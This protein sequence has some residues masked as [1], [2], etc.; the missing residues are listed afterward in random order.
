MSARHTHNEMKIV[1]E[2]TRRGK[3]R[4]KEKK[5][6]ETIACVCVYVKERDRERQHEIDSIHKR[7]VVT[8]ET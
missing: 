1:R 5:R 7:E 4:V 2:K 8:S 3:R 6:E